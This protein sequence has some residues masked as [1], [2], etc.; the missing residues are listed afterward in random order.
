MSRR[1]A[2]GACRKKA[3][4]KLT[5]RELNLATI[6]AG[7]DVNDEASL[8]HITS[9]LEGRKIAVLVIAAG[10]QEMD[11]LGNVTKDIIRY[12]M[13]VPPAV[14]APILRLALLIFNIDSWLT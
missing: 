6:F 7:V 2:G 12:S 9:A 8:Q 4:S 5:T 11:K 10:S 3:V 1:P 14:A 13:T